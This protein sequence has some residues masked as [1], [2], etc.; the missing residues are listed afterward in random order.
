M[1][2]Y[3][4]FRYF[5]FAVDSS[6]MTLR[7]VEYYFIMIMK[8]ALVFAGILGVRLW[9][10]YMLQHF[11]FKLIQSKVNPPRKIN[12][13]K[14]NLKYSRIDKLAIRNYL[15]EIDFNSNNTI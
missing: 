11:F 9:Y 14:Y 10:E 6:L 3:V 15:R 8:R 1:I 13:L 7:L 5:L 4:L 12:W 2:I